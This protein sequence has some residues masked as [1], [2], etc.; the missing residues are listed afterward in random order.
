MK[1]ALED[2][3]RAAAGSTSDEIEFTLDGNKREVFAAGSANL[4]CFVG[5][6]GLMDMDIETPSAHANSVQRSA[7]VLACKS[8]Q[9][10]VPHL[11]RLN[12]TPLVTTS[13]LMAPEAYTL[14]MIIRGW[15]AGDTPA[16]IRDH[17]ATA[18]AKYQR[19]NLSAALKLF[20]AGW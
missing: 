14:D 11:R 10:F 18:Y 4:V 6:N 15:L 20:V 1:R 8:H 2:F 5:H 3:I 19:C 12:C 16:T 9:Y 13:G 17:A 7:V